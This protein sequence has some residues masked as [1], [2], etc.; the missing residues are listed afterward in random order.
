MATDLGDVVALSVNVRDSS[1]A[2]AD[3]TTV[4]L[5]VTLPDGTADEVGTIT[6]TTPGVYEYDYLTTQVGR[7]VVRWVA[8]GVNA[9]VF[10]DVFNVEAADPG[11]LVGLSEVKEHLG[12]TDTDDD[13]ELRRVL[14]AATGVVEGLIGPVARRTVTETHYGASTPLVLRYAPVLSVTSMSDTYGSTYV[15]TDWDL[16]SASGLLRT[17]YGGSFSRWSGDV[18]VTYVVGRSEVP[19]A[20]RLATLELVRHMWES[21]SGGGG[22]RPDYP[23]QEFDQAPSAGYLVP[24]RVAEL[25]RPYLLGPVVA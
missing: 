14:A 9:S 20:V 16:H 15:S 12:R 7:H 25:L 18:T 22:D 11:F 8:T 6:S 23:G 5:T 24:N 19:P 10:V 3:A 1:G 2:L 13:E 17:A 21:Q 4:T